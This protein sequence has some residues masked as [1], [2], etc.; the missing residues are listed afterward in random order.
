MM[1][2]NAYIRMFRRWLWL[3]GAVGLVSGIAGF[4]YGTL[5]PDVYE[6]SVLISVGGYIQSP[7]PA[8]QEVTAGVELAQN[9]AILATTHDVLQSAV[10]ATGFPQTVAELQQDAVSVYVIEE[11]SVLRLG[12][13]YTDP[14]LATALA[15]ELARQLIL[16]SPTDPRLG[17]SGR[18]EVPSNFLEVIEWAQVPT[19]PVGPGRAIL[20]LAG[21]LLGSSFAIG[22]VM[23]IDQLDDS[24]RSADEAVTLLEAPLI[25][26]IPQIR[27]LSKGTEQTL[28]YASQPTGVYTERYRA[29]RTNLLYG[30][31]NHRDR[32]AYIITSIAPQE[33]KTLTAAN[34]A[35]ALAAIGQ[36]VL[37]IDADLRRPRI[38]NLFGCENEYGLTNLLAAAPPSLTKSGDPLQTSEELK[39]CV[40]TTPVDGLRII[41]SGVQ[42]PNPAELLGSPAMKEWFTVLQSSNELD[43]IL[44]DTPPALV[45]SDSF[46]LVAT[47]DLPILMVL[48]A[49][50]TKRKDIQEFCQQLDQLGLSVRGLVLNAVPQRDLSPLYKPYGDYGDTPASG[51]RWT[52]R[53]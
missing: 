35:I 14:Y 30:A 38:H 18:R 47:I 52:D 34:L 21:L 40:R 53:F 17:V 2:L 1:D 39:R 42:V 28:V 15:N 51:G 36:H 8:P 27:G 44:I 32:K 10:D 6:A 13:K 22:A 46:V 7:D 4:L 37:L 19:K 25:G 24:L 29:L 45:V 12:V 50:T 16:I 11:T 20:A 49:G 31:E 43:M 26:T 5:Q 33:G 3:I 23:V 9:Y 48:K 41:T